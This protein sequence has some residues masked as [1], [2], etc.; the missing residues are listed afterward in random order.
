M[1]I[2][3]SAIAARYTEGLDGLPLRLPC[4][5][6]HVY[7]RYV[8]ATP[9]R[10]ALEAHLRSCG[11]EAK[12]PVYQPA[13]HYVGGDFPNAEAAHREAL[14]LPIYPSLLEEEIEHVLDSVHSFF[15]W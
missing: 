1:C 11:V 7:Y 15:A 9:E 10:D 14:S 5:A 12:R 13:H 3:D 4:G 8:V 6:D 2:R